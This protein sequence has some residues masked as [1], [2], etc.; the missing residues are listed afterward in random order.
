MALLVRCDCGA[1]IRADHE[2]ELVT[3]VQRHAA[4]QHGMALALD[5]AL[6]LAFQAELSQTYG[7]SVGARPPSTPAKPEHDPRRHDR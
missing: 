4:K 3:R 7:S 1:Q 6:L 5:E 2:R